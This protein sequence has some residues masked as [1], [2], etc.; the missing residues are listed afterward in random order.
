MQK[1]FM[2]DDGLLVYFPKVREKLDDDDAC[3]NKTF[4]LSNY[5]IAVVSATVNVICELSRKNPS[6]YLLLAPPLYS[7]LTTSH[8]TWMLIKIV[9]LFGALCPLEPR[10]KK[11][12]APPIMDLIS[13]T[14]AVSLL[15]EC[16]HSVIVGGMIEDDDDGLAELCFEKL[17]G[18]IMEDQTDQN[19][20]FTLLFLE[21]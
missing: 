20:K 12:L 18:F 21:L 19:C 9:K 14:K 15:Y 16:I 1:A 11:K 17:G 6:D 5:F 8:N 7:L 13:T 10:L 2:V 4:T 3:K